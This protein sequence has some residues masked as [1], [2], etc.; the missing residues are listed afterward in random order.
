MR[1]QLLVEVKDRLINQTFS[2]KTFYDPIFFSGQVMINI[3]TRDQI[4]V[5]VCEMV[6]RRDSR[7]NENIGAHVAGVVAAAAAAERTSPHGK[8]KGRERRNGRENENVNGKEN[9]V[10]KKSEWNA[11]LRTWIFRQ[12]IPHPRQSR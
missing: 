9:L 3:P 11:K 5:A 10:E 8:E 6:N 2:C 12:A 1:I 4:A 7:I